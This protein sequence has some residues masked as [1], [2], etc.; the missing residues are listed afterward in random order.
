MSVC[1]VSAVCVVCV[2]ACE[3]VCVCGLA[4]STNIGVQILTNT[5]LAFPITIIV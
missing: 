1:C 3:C 5:I 2:C 4:K